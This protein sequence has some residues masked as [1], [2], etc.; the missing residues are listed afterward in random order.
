M[1]VR[2]VKGGLILRPY[3][4][5]VPLCTGKS[6]RREYRTEKLRSG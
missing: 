2:V 5:L 3:S 4:R 6:T 1:K